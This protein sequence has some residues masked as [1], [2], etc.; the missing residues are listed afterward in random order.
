ML[1][2]EVK[3]GNV[4]AYKEKKS[5]L[6]RV[7]QILK[8]HRDLMFNGDESKPISII[9]TTLAARAYNKETD[10]LDALVNVVNSMERYIEH[11]PN[12]DLCIV[13]NPVNPDENFADKWVETPQKQLNFFAWLK[14]VKQDVEQIIEKRGGLQLIAESMNKPFGR[15]VVQRTFSAIA[16]NQRKNRDNNTL[17]ATI[18]GT[19][20][21][22]G[23][24]VKAHTFHGDE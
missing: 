1:F 14:Q 19:L 17:R 13:R 15:D 7:V 12:T 8:R 4:P 11:E 20:G 18:T 16:D 5:P 6:Q 21:I 3:V 23:T 2:S 22:V 9:I 24:V 10:V